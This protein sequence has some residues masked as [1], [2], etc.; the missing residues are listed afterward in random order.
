[1]A[2]KFSTLYDHHDGPELH[3]FE[4]TRTKQEF[5]QEADI[6]YILEQYQTTGMLPANNGP[7]PAFADFTDPALADFQTAQ[8]LVIGARDMFDHL[9]ARIRERFNNDPA[10]LILFMQDPANRKEAE[11]L[12]LVNRPPEPKPE[13]ESNKDAK[14]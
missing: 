6:N 1:M 14:P 4:P 2:P 9:D 12:G 5:A 13:P 7:E 11:D 3:D 8:N 10:T